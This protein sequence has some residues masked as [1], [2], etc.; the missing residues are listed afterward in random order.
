M[1]DAVIGFLQTYGYAAVFVSIF[2]ESTGLPF[3]GESIL[4][5]AGI[6]AGHGE[7]NVWGVV[8]AS[9]AG[10]TLG[11]N[12][13][14]YLGHRFGR[15]FVDRYGSKF[16]MTPEKFR[17][18]EARFQKVGPPIVLIARVI[19]V[20]RQLAGFVAGT[21]RFPW[22]EFLLYNALGAAL[23]SG[24]YGFGS[25]IL[26]DR[27]DHYLHGSPWAYAA[28]AVVFLTLTATTLFKFRKSVKK[29]K[30]E[31]ETQSFSPEESGEGGSRLR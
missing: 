2:L 5:A 1:F 7:L 16:G 29:M 31:A 19:L 27:I 24:A 4:I 11:D 25:Y 13:G 26:G 28:I 9:W 18:V 12:L 21:L 20:L 15:R 10:G 6:M 8:G 14:Y 3:P 17:L 23:W 30:Q 22:W